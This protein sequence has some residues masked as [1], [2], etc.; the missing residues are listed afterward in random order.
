MNILFAIN[1]ANKF[2]NAKGIISSRLDCE[3]LLSK[4]TQSN[5]SDILLN[6][7]K[8]ISKKE[9]DHIKKIIEQTTKKKPI[10]YYWKK[11]FGKMNFMFL[12]MY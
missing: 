9:L 3:I 11:N 6:Q 1:Q 8:E 2:L 10:I 5:R 12:K 4:V 7:D